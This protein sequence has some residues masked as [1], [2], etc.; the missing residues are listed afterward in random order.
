MYL[1]LAATEAPTTLAPIVS[2]MTTLVDIMGEVW[3][4]MTGNPLLVFFL[5]VSLFSVGIRV[6]KKV[7]GAAK[8]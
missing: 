7:K 3:S 5:G 1:A 8:R 4:V 6:F 2:S